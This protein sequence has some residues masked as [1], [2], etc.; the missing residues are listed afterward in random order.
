MVQPT[1]PDDHSDQ[2]SNINTSNNASI[3]ASFLINGVNNHASIQ[4]PSSDQ[5][6]E[7]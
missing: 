1:Q 3:D 6:T 2:N 5:H 7:L 4:H